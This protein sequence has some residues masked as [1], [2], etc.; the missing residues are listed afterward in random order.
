MTMIAWVMIKYRLDQFPR[1][2]VNIF[3]Q[4]IIDA[5]EEFFNKKCFIQTLIISQL[6]IF[7]I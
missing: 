7:L 5:E 1:R 3:D 4:I 2:R 6:I